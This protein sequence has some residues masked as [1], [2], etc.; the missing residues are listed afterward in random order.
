MDTPPYRFRS[1]AMKRQL[2]A[3]VS[4]SALCTMAVYAAPAGEPRTT[5]AG[6]FTADQAERGSKVFEETCLSC[7]QPDEFSQPGYMDGWVGQ[8]ANDFMDLIRT[9]MPQDNP[10]RLKRDECVDLVAF[11]FR[12]NGLPVGESEMDMKTIKEIVIEGPFGGE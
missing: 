2:A 10:G 7:H 4:A 12:E 1:K 6:V 8:T 11:L 5:Q 9:T 3:L